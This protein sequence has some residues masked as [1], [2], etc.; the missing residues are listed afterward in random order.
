[1]S[2]ET[3][4][5]QLKKAIKPLEK[6]VHSSL[7]ERSRFEPIAQQH[8]IAQ[9]ALKVIEDYEPNSETDSQ[10]KAEIQQALLEIKKV[11]NDY[12]QLWE[13][14]ESSTQSSVVA[15]LFWGAASIAGPVVGAE[16]IE[17]NPLV[18]HVLMFSPVISFALMAIC[19]FLTKWNNAYSEEKETLKRIETIQENL[20]K[21]SQL[22]SK[23]DESGNDGRTFPLTSVV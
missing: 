19:L 3:R 12:A 14:H 10:T 1:M 21:Q 15:C 13:E 11:A 22:Q 20:N 6:L 16:I 4:E 7:S 23:L 9:S 8:R 5:Q 17:S 18:G 2:T